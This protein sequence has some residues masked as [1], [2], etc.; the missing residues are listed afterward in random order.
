MSEWVLDTRVIGFSTSGRLKVFVLNPIMNDELGRTFLYSY[1]I[2]L[3]LIK[4]LFCF[5]YG[6]YLFKVFLNKMFHS[7]E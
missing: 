5:Y 7:L 2:S 6:L 3:M 1:L 4:D